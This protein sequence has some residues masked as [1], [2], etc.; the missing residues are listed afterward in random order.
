MILRLAFASLLVLTVAAPLGSVALSTPAQ[1]KYSMD[2][3]KRF[4]GLCK[5]P[6]KFAAGAC[7]KRCPAGYRDTGRG[8]CR[9]K[10][11][12]R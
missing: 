12:N 2:R 8:Y 7:V 10:N 4:G 11:M 9:F 3:E 1:A 6:L 5:P